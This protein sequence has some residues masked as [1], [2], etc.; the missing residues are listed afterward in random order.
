LVLE[1]VNQSTTK[2][3]FIEGVIGWPGMINLEVIE[4]MKRVQDRFGGSLFNLI[5]SYLPAVPKKISEEIAE[6]NIPSEALA[7]FEYKIFNES[8]LPSTAKKTWITV[9]SKSTGR[10]EAIRS[11]ICL[12]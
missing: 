8:D 4:H 7:K 6:S 9:F 10:I 1:R 3:K 11:A 5:D 12:D 2:L